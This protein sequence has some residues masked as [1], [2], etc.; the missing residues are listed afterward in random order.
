MFGYNTENRT[1]D[2]TT[3]SGLTL[4]GAGAKVIKDKF[5]TGRC[6][7]QSNVIK[8]DVYLECC[9]TWLEFSITS[10]G[11]DYCED[12]CTAE[13]DLQKITEASKCYNYLNN[14]IY[15]KEGFADAFVHPRVHYCSQPG[16]VQ[17]LFLAMMPMLA[18]IVIAL[19][20]IVAIVKT[21]CEIVTIGFGRC[22]LGRAEDV[23]VCSLY[24][25]VGGCGRYATSP[26]IKDILEYHTGAC[27]LRLQSSIFQQDPHQNLALFQ[28]QY[29]KGVTGNVNFQEENAANLTPIQLL[30][31]LVGVYNLDYRIIGNALVVERKDYFDNLGLSLGEIT[32]CFRFVGDKAFAYGRFEYTDD[33][34]DQQSNRMATNYDDIIEWNA[35]NADWKRGEYKPTNTFGRARFMFDQRG[36]DRPDDVPGGD[37]EPFLGDNFADRFRS[38]RLFT[39]FGCADDRRER[40]LLLTDSRASQLKLLVLEPGFNPL[41]AHT[42]RKPYEPG[43]FAYN[44]PM[45]YREDEPDG[46][47]QQFHAIDDPNVSGRYVYEADDAEIVFDCSLFKRIQREEGGYKLTTSMG[48]AVAETVE[49]NP[50]AGTITAKGLK[51][52]CR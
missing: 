20:V 49:I 9:S 4:K 16:F 33:Q 30:E 14:T 28:L 35:E 19:Q 17:F 34:A 13:I 45:Y 7:D 22:D 11:V 52:K 26:L 27:G 24:D 50:N 38:T 10:E 21:V 40:D 48:E 42:I 1:Y 6:A 43:F 12:E 29:E 3:A 18:T 44:Y 37:N 15:W 32:T 5:F 25:I 39:V 46:L 41:D 2:Y 36:F 8:V 47:Y 51:I 23:S 31:R